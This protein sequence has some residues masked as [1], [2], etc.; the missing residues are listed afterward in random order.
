VRNSVHKSV[1]NRWQ[2]DK[3]S[4][5]LMLVT[6]VKVQRKE[7]IQYRIFTSDQ[8]PIGSVRMTIVIVPLRHDPNVSDTNGHHMSQANVR[9]LEKY[10][11]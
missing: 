10:Q 3:E 2:N 8:R 6:K 9:V 11:R 1:L 4:T 5:V 7:A